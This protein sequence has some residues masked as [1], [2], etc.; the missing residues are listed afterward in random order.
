MSRP[1]FQKDS[2]TPNEIEF[3]VIVQIADQEILGM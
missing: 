3:P 1:H 2:V